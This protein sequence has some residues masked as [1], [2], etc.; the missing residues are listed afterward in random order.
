MELALEGL[1]SVDTL[2]TLL[3][4]MATCM[5]WTKVDHVNSPTIIGQKMYRLYHASKVKCHQ[6][7]ISEPFCRP[8]PW[9]LSMPQRWPRPQTPPPQ[10]GT[11]QTDCLQIVCHENLVR[12][13]GTVEELHA[14]WKE[15]LPQPFE[16]AKLL[17]QKGLSNN[18]QVQSF[19]KCVP[20]VTIF[21]SQVSHALT[22]SNSMPSG[23][24]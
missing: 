18:F 4:V 13:P 1:L 10:T 7:V 9:A 3:V 19:R 24:R 21:V 17:V 22:M 15:M 2:P 12:N 6:G 23:Y 16:G 5:Y 20:I 14:R 8:P 11:F